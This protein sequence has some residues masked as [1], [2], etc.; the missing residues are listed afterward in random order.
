MYAQ[1]TVAPPK[2]VMG[3][4]GMLPD[5]TP[6]TTARTI[7][8]NHWDKD[9]PVDPIVIAKKMGF[10][11]YLDSGLSS[12]G[13]F[14]IDQTG[15][16][17]I[18]LR[19][20]E[21]ASRQRFAVAHELGHSCLDHGPQKETDNSVYSLYNLHPVDRAANHFALALI[22]PHSAMEHYS[23]QGIALKNL[24]KKFNVTTQAMEFRLGQLG[25]ALL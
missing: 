10:T 24:S 15:Q 20:A 14:F 5:K 6:E 12:L 23:C 13:Q 9:L 7:L 19:P 16:R 4:G 8:R 1:L 22:M 18:R 3:A 25:L 21:L 17:S 11:V 2:R